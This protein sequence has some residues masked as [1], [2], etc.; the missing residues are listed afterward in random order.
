MFSRNTM[1]MA[2]ATVLLWGQ[3][4]LAQG[5]TDLY[6]ITNSVSRSHVEYHALPIANG[7]EYVLAD[8]QGP[9]KITYFYVTPVSDQL[10]LKVYW[11]GEAEPSILSPLPDFFG[12]MRGK[13]VD[14]HAQ[15]MEIEHACYMCYLPMP[16]SKRAKFVLANDS[17]RDYQNPEVL[18][19]M[20]YGIDYEKA[21]RFAEEKSRLHCMWRRNNPVKDGAEPLDKIIKPTDCGG[22]NV[23]NTRHTI[24]EATGRG[25]YVGHFLHV[26]TQNTG[27]WGEGVT[28]FRIDGQWMAHSA[29][30][31]DEYGSCWGFGTPF[32]RPYCG[33]LPDGKGG[34]LVYRWYVANPVRFQKS[35]KVDIQDLYEFG[36]GGDDYTTTAFWYQEEPHK[37]I[38]APAVRRADRAEQGE[39]L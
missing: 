10:V 30:T 8:L 25:H 21:P 38:L 17:G 14:Y 4:A 34:N 7:K 12:A 2:C 29:G 22:K 37:A 35:I 13:T 18:D 23:V 39:G 15:P 6:R 3:S 28:F 24:L 32:S 5:L 20:A 26:N 1:T 19:N 36:P 33:F 31:E 11:D 9:G 16:F 27:W